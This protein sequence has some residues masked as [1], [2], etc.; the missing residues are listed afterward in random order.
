MKKTLNEN[1]DN[2]I[3][4]DENR[5]K[6]VN[7]ELFFRKNKF[8]AILSSMADGLF[9]IDD[10]FRITSFNRAAEEITGYK[11]KEVLGKPCREIIH[12][13][14]CHRIS[15][16][17]NRSRKTGKP[18]LN[19]K[20]FIKSKKR[21]LIYISAST[22]ALKDKDGN[23]IGGVETF[24]DMT[25]LYKIEEEKNRLIIELQNINKELDRLNKMKSEFISVVSHEL[26]TPLT[27][28]KGYTELLLSS[29][30]GNVTKDQGKVLEIVAKKANQL[31]KLIIQLLDLSRI[32][33]GKF[34]LE[35]EPL[36]LDKILESSLENFK[37]IFEEK[38]IKYKA[39]LLKEP[40]WVIGNELRLIEVM[41]NL[42]SNAVKFTPV[43]GRIV[44]NFK[45]LQGKVEVSV[46]D[47]GQ[48]I[49]EN[50]FENIFNSF[51]QIDSS[52]TRKYSG[53]GLGLAIVK[54]IIDGHN[55]KIWVKSKL[56][57]GSTFTFTLPIAEAD[58][59]LKIRDII[60]EKKK[61]YKENNK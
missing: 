16:A 57:K 39:N 31:N 29:K 36:I 6:E 11:E 58:S 47:S 10:K 37:T 26:R 30:Y 51:Y 44:I 3:L 7:N 8:E 54:H 34:E 33:L 15:C 12:G 43:K 32:E 22:S 25:E 48:G 53:A 55:G 42:L 21:G 49:P 9:T 45:K 1:I 46:Q 27:A 17:L 38:E 35:K 56:N 5:I 4:K 13:E 60:R 24:H 40:V 59:V 2:E 41:D 23:F 52:S 18:H 20:T 14:L 19:V 50:E 61:E 28:I